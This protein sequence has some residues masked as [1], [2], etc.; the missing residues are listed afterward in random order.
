MTERSP[1]I[2]GHLSTPESRD[3]KMQ[4]RPLTC[5]EASKDPQVPYTLSWILNMLLIRINGNTGHRAGREQRGR[6]E[7]IWLICLWRAI[8][9]F[10]PL[11]DS[12][13]LE[14]F[15]YLVILTLQ[16]SQTM[17]LSL[18]HLSVEKTIPK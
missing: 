10:C 6:P 14:A 8:A 15:L 13:L 18:C 17:K 9:L 7:V 3:M 11:T 4:A 2:S 16:F 5:C 1:L 12:C